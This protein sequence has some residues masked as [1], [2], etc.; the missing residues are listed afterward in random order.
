MKKNNSRDGAVVRRVR[1]KKGFSKIFQGKV[2]RYCSRISE[3]EDDTPS[4]TIVRIL[5]VVLL[6]HLIVI[7]GVWLRGTL[8]KDEADTRVAIPI[9]QETSS[10]TQQQQAKNAIPATDQTLITDKN[11]M[12]EVASVSP[13][14]NSAGQSEQ[15]PSAEPLDGSGASLSD[16]PVTPSVSAPKPPIASV[17]SAVASNKTSQ[18]VVTPPAPATGPAEPGPARHIVATGDT[19]DTIARDNNCGVDAL[20][21]VNSGAVLASGTTLVIPMKPGEREKVVKARQEEAIR[22]ADAVYVMKRGDTLSKVARKYKISVAALQKHND[23]T[24]PRKVRI[25]QELRIP[26]Q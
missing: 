16:K 12:A 13:S 11:S 9:A 10:Q 22:N 1:P 14:A 15:I 3:F 2:T 24:D 23:I 21:S 8:K 19:W 5:V 20:K 6:I 17:P 25:G 4:S 26:K 18:Q 7:G